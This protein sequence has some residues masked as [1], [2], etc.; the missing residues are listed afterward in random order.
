M[1]LL[2][3]NIR[4]AT[5]NGRHHLP[6]PGYGY[7]RRTH[8]N[9]DRLIHF[10]KEI[11]PDIL[12]LI[13]VDL[14]SY[15]TG[16]RLSQAELIAQALGQRHIHACK[17]S[18][19]SLQQRMPF[20]GKLGNA[21]ITRENFADEKFHYF[22]RGVKRLIIELELDSVQIFLVHLSLGE[23]ARRQQLRDIGKLIANATKPV[24]VA[25]DFNTFY[26]QREL[27]EIRDTYDLLSANQHSLPTHPA[28]SPT[29][30]LDFVLYDPRVK[31]N[32]FAILTEVELSDHLP[33][34]IDFES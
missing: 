10:F 23:A 2:V 31:L 27:N 8:R 29:R 7:L 5:G 3:Y 12:G 13:E 28:G 1:R 14:G 22:T 19:G 18:P 26:G 16:H 9:L 24:I 15:R 20:F 11:D 6:F 33:L 21:F 30:E 25:G 4:Y 34:L 32:R 17:Y